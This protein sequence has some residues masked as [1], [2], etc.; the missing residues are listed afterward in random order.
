MLASMLDSF[1]VSADI[2]V[3]MLLFF[4]NLSSK[5]A[6]NTPRD[7][8]QHIFDNG[9]LLRTATRDQDEGDVS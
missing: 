4:T 2:S 8:R 1:T 5:W 7:H 9:G 3:P 6:R